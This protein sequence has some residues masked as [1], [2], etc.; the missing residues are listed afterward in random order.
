MISAILM[1]ALMASDAPAGGAATTAATTPAP[2]TAPAAKPKTDDLICHNEHDL[3]S[4]IPHRV[5]RHQSDIDS[6]AEQ[7]RQTLEQI[8]NG[9]RVGSSH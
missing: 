2:V 3:G 5:C 4:N 1:L 9:T 7:D 8:Q 6:R